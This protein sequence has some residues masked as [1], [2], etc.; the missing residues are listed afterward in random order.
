MGFLL[1]KIHLSGMNKAASRIGHE[2]PFLTPCQD[3]ALFYS[4][5]DFSSTARSAMAAGTTAAL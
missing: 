3:T 2:A 5:P 4:F 1:C